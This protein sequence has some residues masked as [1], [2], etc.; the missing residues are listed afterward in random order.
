MPIELENILSSVEEF[1]CR[2]YGVIQTSYVD[3]AKHRLFLR[4]GKPENL[5]PT[6]DALS[7][8]VKRFHYHVMI[9]HDAHYGT[10]V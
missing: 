8:H 7:F 6:S 2:L 9:W 1:I 3:A 10:L 4:R 5:P